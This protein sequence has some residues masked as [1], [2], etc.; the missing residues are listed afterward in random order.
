[1]NTNIIFYVKELFLIPFVEGIPPIWFKA[2]TLSSNTDYI[3]FEITFIPARSRSLLDN[4][5][6]QFAMGSFKP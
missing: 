5:I 4:F 3:D 1:M 2:R 6:T